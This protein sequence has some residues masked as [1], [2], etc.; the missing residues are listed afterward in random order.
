MKG[1]YRSTT[2][3]QRFPFLNEP[4]VNPYLS[5]LGRS[6]IDEYKSKGYEIKQ[7]QGWP[8]E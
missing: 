7:T 8:Q 2:T 1:F 3:G 4:N 6:V 5:P